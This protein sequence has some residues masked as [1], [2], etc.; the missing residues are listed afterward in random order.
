MLHEFIQDGV[1]FF[2]HNGYT[3]QGKAFIETLERTRHTEKVGE[4][5]FAVKP[6]AQKAI[7]PSRAKRIRTVVH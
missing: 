1:R 2:S 7:A 5:L 6:S 3:P 4:N